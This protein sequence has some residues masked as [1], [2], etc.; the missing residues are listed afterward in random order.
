MS[1][2]RRFFE[3]ELAGDGKD[4]DRNDDSALIFTVVDQS[5]IIL[6]CSHLFRNKFVSE[7]PIYG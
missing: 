2:A 1:H 3:N 5:L 7:K 4:D 6:I